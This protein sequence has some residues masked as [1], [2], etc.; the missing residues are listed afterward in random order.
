MA[1]KTDEPV[2][3]ESKTSA[4]DPQKKYLDIQKWS[5]ETITYC[6]NLMIDSQ[7]ITYASHK[8]NLFM[9]LNLLDYILLPAK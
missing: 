1:K 4:V 2:A 6:N 3:E 5:L 8:S 7:L 9:D